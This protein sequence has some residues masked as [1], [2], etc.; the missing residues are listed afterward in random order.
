MSKKKADM[1][2]KTLK[3]EIAGKVIADVLDDFGI[4]PEDFEA[5]TRRDIVIDRLRDTDWLQG[6]EGTSNVISLAA[7][8][9]KRAAQ[10]RQFDDDYRSFYEYERRARTGTRS[11]SDETNV[12]P[13]WCVNPE[14]QLAPVSR[15]GSTHTVALRWVGPGEAEA[16]DIVLF[17]DGVSS[18]VNDRRG[19]D[20][21][22]DIYVALEARVGKAIPLDRFETCLE[23][24]GT[25]RIQLWTKT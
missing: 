1:T 12:A 17:I 10:T 9:E 2:P 21:S 13:G 11:L 16:S 6:T 8:R 3:P 18:P 20:R 24:D 14:A 19:S 5:R 7:V 15:A 23:E 22:L 4:N 25:L